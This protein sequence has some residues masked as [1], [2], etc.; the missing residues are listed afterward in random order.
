MKSVDRREREQ[1]WDQKMA[2]AEK[3]QKKTQSKKGR[4]SERQGARVYEDVKKDE[5]M[6]GWT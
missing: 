3:K 2:R 1:E 5:R 6:D 4:A